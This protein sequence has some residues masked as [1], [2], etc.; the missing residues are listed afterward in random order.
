MYDQG[1]HVGYRTRRSIRHQPA[2]NLKPKLMKTVAPLKRTSTTRTALQKRVAELNR[3][4]S[5]HLSSDPAR[6]LGLAQ[7]AHALSLEAH[8][9]SGQAQS[10]LNLGKLQHNAGDL[11]RALEHA[12]QASALFESL[13]DAHG[14]TE[15]LTDIGRM[16]RDTGRLEKA[17]E[18][19]ALALESASAR[20]DTAAE[21]GALNV[22][23]SVYGRLGRFTDAIHD[24]D[25]VL[26]IRIMYR[27]RHGEAVALMNLGIV[28]TELGD[29]ATGLENLLGSHTIITSVLHD[30][31]LETKCL[32]NIGNVYQDMGEYESA[33][34]HFGRSLELTRV[35]EEP[36]NEVIALNN[37]AEA[38]R[39]LGDHHQAA[40]MLT[41]ALEKSR[42]IGF[43][44]M[45]MQI[46]NGLGSVYHALKDYAQGLSFH[47]AAL[48]LARASGDAQ[49]KMEAL[50]G[51]GNASL[52]LEQHASAVRYFT[53]AL[54]A[55]QKVKQPRTTAEAHRQL[56]QAYEQHG[57]LER[58][59]AHLR[60]YHQLERR[61]FN[62]DNARKTRNLSLQFDL[63]RA[64]HE[65][66]VHRIN[67]EAAQQANTILEEKVR[68]RTQELEEAGIEVV[69][70]LAVA[71]EYRDDSTGQ[72]TW[73]VGRTSALLA[74]ELGLPVTEVELIHLAAR[75]H[76]VGK[77]GITDLILQK[78]ARLTVD[79]FDRMKD[80]T[81]IGAQILSGGKTPL[82]KMAEEIALTHHER[83]D[84]SGYP[85]GKKG[86][87]I[88]MV[89]RIVAVADV[90]DALMS[91]RPYKQ[92]WNNA[93]A[94]LE[95]ER[96]AG[97]HFD[98]RVV[99]AL[100]TLLDRG[101]DLT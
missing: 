90:F 56:A 5:Q 30:P 2:Q 40:L 45:E 54:R 53:Q 68:E 31:Q 18:V 58:T 98:P 23:A 21:A 9:L 64:R 47:K 49:V 43:G 36:I 79:E 37:L 22:R 100:K 69:T 63:E 8:D 76:D 33:A 6:A 27:D 20:N 12:L 4:T 67:H 19:L 26:V 77:I 75:L 32:L 87:H 66:E 65:M 10:L 52:G 13:E 93:E 62:E 96:Q 38:H 42:K 78:P 97:R 73:R 11:E 55:S 29:Y 34:E 83:W 86:K 28:Y 1:K 61:V 15:C 74:E 92:A 48:R 94:Y 85:H 60:A 25:Q 24:F 70:R 51:L 57:D 39:S 84:G 99:R 44:G 95:I 101:I 88:P 80:H 50:M 91:P 82:L 14:Q 17:L 46:E 41:E 7:Q 35:H 3:Q 72:H 16:H 89:G 81:V 71:A 59:I